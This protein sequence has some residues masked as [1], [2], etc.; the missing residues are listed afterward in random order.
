MVN[1]QLFTTTR[2]ALLPAT[3]ARNAERAPAYGF[4]AHHALAQYAATGALN[5]TFYADEREQLTTVLAL[6]TEIDPKFIARTAIWAREQG[7]MKDMPALLLAVLSMRNTRLLEHVFE[8]V[9]DNGKMLRNFVQ[10]MRSGAVGRKSLGTTSKRL[11]QRWLEKRSDD[12]IFR[13]SI[14]SAPSFADVVKMV[15]P[16]PSSASRKALYAWLIGRPHDVE[17]LPACVRELETWKRDR[18]RPLPDAP[19]EML[20]SFDLSNTEWKALARRASWQ[21]TR[22]NL[23]TFM[24]HGVF[25]DECDVRGGIIPSIARWLGRSMHGE[26]STSETNESDIVDALATRLRDP[27]AIA[28]ARVFPYQILVAHRNASAIGTLPRA[29]LAALEAALEI[30]TNNVPTFAGKVWICPDVSGSMRS[31][32]TGKRKGAT[33]SVRCVDVAA[34]VAACVLRKNATAEVLPFEREVVSVR[35]RATDSVMAN[36][37]A[38]AKVGGGGTN[39]S[40]P[41]RLLN[42]CEAAGDLVIYV[43]DNESWV[44]AGG[45]RGTRMLAEWEC[46]RRRNPNARLVC[47]D[48]Q[49]NR[50][51]QALERPDILNIGGFSDHVFTLIGEF[52]AGR[53]GSGRWV[54]AIEGIDL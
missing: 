14:G 38:L 2:G 43:S 33:S 46:F 21:Q 39:C 23:N 18:S 15:H 49:P 10:V 5:A 17:A 30:A 42:E 6:C 12:D 29:L 32:V 1:K 9:V 54:E 19:F 8:R 3:D 51:T 28:R 27:L 48:V 44:D 37:A 35:V 45:A 7:H 11:V 36:A 34:L 50:T 47:L 24:R 40:A 22:M 52:A 53:R 31:P 25:G 13:A 16:K 41:L 4:D 20:T 26:V